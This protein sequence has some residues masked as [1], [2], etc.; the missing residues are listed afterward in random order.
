[1][2]LVLA[3]ASAQGVYLVWLLS[4][5]RWTAL[6]PTAGVAE[7][8]GLATFA[9]V[10]AVELVRAVQ[11][12]SLWVF[13]LAARDSISSYSRAGAAIGHDLRCGSTGVRS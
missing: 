13:G 6:S 1:V 12:V 4:P 3:D 9:A 2:L 11:C 8:A 7:L 10:A 5:A